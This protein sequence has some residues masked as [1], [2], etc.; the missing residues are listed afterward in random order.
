MASTSRSLLVA[1]VPAVKTLDPFPPRTDFLFSHYSTRVRGVRENISQS[2]HS[3]LPRAATHTFTTSVY[4][5][6]NLHPVDDFPQFPP[7]C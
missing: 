6:N 2:Y 4:D 7:A 3:L 1:T 5:T